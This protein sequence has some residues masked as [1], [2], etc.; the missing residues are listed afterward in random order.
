[1]TRTAQQDTKQNGPTADEESIE[2]WRSELSRQNIQ[3][4]TNNA[5]RDFFV[6]IIPLGFYWLF[7]LLA[8]DSTIYSVCFLK[9]EG[10]VSF[11]NA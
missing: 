2:Q 1:M 4:V 9:E 5:K 6:A 8:P 3:Y 10:W 11:L 7:Y